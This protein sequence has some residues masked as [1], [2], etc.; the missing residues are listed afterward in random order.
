MI[1]SM[2]RKIDKLSVTIDKILKSRGMQ[3][4]LQEY[5]ISGQWARTV[6]LAIARHAQPLTLRGGRLVL[7]VDSPAWMQQL[8]LMRPEIIEKLNHNVGAQTVREITLKLGEIASSPMQSPAGERI[9][10]EITPEERQRIEQSLHVID[11]DD[12]R[13]AIKRMIEK[14]LLRKK[15]DAGR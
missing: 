9:P 3:S 5:R 8:S 14:D 12:I 4:R 1:G 15:G 2:A 13:D 7:I 10:A 6:G 11:D